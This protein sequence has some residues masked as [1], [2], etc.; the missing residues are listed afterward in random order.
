MRRLA[1]CSRDT[2]HVKP[3]ILNFLTMC[4]S[5]MQGTQQSP[6]IQGILA[7]GADACDSRTSGQQ[8]GMPAIHPRQLAVKCYDAYWGAEESLS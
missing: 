6:V 4:S 7:E 8:P 5:M 2:L 1:V 3:A